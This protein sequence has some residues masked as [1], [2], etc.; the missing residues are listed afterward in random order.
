MAATDYFVS[1]PKREVVG[2]D[3]T[4]AN[5]SS[6]TSS[7]SSDYIELRMRT[8]DGSTVATGLTKK[9]VLIALRVFERWIKDGGVIGDGSNLPVL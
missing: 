8:V 3:L 9:D 1:V 4:N 5:L 6:G 7:A 2:G